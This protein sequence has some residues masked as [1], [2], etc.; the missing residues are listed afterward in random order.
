VAEGALDV[1]VSGRPLAP[2]EAGL[3]LAAPL[4]ARTPFVF[5][6]GPRV[7]IS[8]ITSVELA[9]LYR[10]EVTRWPDGERVRLVLRPRTD[11]DT[12]VVRAISPELDAAMELALRRE[13]MLV[14]ATNQDCDEALIRTPGSLGPSSLTQLMTESHTLRALSWNGVAPTL[15][16][17]GSGAYPL[18]KPLHL[19]VRAAPTRAVRQFLE[20]LGGAEARRIL[21][22]TGNLPVPMPPLP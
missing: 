2:A 22:Q 3:G 14:A 7:P 16:N 9:R 17:L 11:V 8:G 6:V 13:G 19:V 5:A 20:F 10:G 1:G 18:S 15:Q 12:M 4:L 21:E